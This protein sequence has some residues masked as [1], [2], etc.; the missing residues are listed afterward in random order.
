MNAGSID[1]LVILDNVQSYNLFQRVSQD[2]EHGSD[3]Q[4]QDL[5]PG[6]YRDD[7]SYDNIADKDPNDKMKISINIK[8]L[9]MSS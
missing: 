7:P 2:K 6:Y 3:Y 9:Q 4:D 5:L 1:G 8:H